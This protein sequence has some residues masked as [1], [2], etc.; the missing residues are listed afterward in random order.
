MRRLRPQHGFTIIEML[1]C[2]SLLAILISL[3]GVTYSRGQRDMIGFSRCATDIM[4]T[5]SAGEKWREDVR[6]AT[7]PPALDDGVLVIPQANG[8]LMYRFEKNTVVRKRSTDN[9]WRPLLKNVKNSRMMADRGK[10]VTSWR[11]E[12]ELRQRA[13]EARVQPLFTF[14]AVPA[15]RE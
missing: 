8:A 6:S 13:R 14:Q 15:K 4:L 1:V 9:K 10:H 2:I 7:A 11:W 3:V 5:V 12:V